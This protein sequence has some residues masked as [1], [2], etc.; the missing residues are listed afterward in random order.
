MIKFGKGEVDPSTIE[1]DG[2]NTADAPDFV[3]AYISY[4]EYTDG[5]E[6]TDQELDT[7]TDENSDLVYDKVQETIY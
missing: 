1:I 5:T 4:A 2:I 7:L 6:L 3:D